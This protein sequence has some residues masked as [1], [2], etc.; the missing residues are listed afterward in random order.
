[1]TGV[2]PKPSHGALGHA[3]P[4]P[5]TLQPAQSSCAACT[6]PHGRVQ[7]MLLPKLAA[8][9]GAKDLLKRN[10]HSPF[11]T[12]SQGAR[13]MWTCVRHQA[14]PERCGHLH[15]ASESTSVGHLRMA[16]HTMP[17]PCSAC[18]SGSNSWCGLAACTASAAD[19]ILDN[20]FAY[21]MSRARLRGGARSAG[22]TGVGRI[23]SAAAL[24][25]AAY[26]SNWTV[27]WS[28]T[29]TPAFWM[30]QQCPTPSPSQFAKSALQHLAFK[31]QVGRFNHLEQFANMLLDDTTLSQF[32]QHLSQRNA[33]QFPWAGLRHLL[34]WLGL[35][36]PR[37]S[38][39]MVAAVQSR[40]VR[41]EY[42]RLGPNANPLAQHSRPTF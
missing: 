28:S 31:F 39:A 42:L 22:C 32:H 23:T 1:M 27:A 37:S 34:T 11:V 5:R 18:C 40:A 30:S 2:A 6:G 9:K 7:T 13:R 17:V 10:T 33:L 41:W 19:K 20:N 8:I 26:T 36:G 24:G 14:Q 29:A 25:L 12:L 38:G 16:V 4:C 35:L 3:A 15:C 21:A